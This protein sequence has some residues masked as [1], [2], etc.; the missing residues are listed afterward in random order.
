M[1]LK[2]AIRNN[3]PDRRVLREIKENRKK[4]FDLALALK[5]QGHAGDHATVMAAWDVL[6]KAEHNAKKRIIGE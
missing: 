3:L 1:L 5:Q 6:S 2:M 4:L